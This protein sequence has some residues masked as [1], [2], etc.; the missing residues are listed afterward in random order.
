MPVSP[1]LQEDAGAAVGWSLASFYQPGHAL[2]AAAITG[3]RP[4]KRCTMMMW[5]LP[6]RDEPSIQ[7]GSD[8]ATRTPFAQLLLHLPGSDVPAVLSAERSKDPSRAATVLASTCVVSRGFVDALQAQASEEA[9]RLA[10]AAL[11]HRA[12]VKQAPAASGAQQGGCGCQHATASVPGQWLG[13]AGL[14]RVQRGVHLMV[15]GSRAACR[16]QQGEQSCQ[17]AASSLSGQCMCLCMEPVP[18]IEQ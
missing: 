10:D 18:G 14:H 7:Q 8:F 9:R 12:P 11:K 3:L 1:C 17:A 16:A 15:C 6:C 4:S 13:T 2:H 5:L